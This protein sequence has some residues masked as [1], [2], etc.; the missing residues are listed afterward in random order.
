MRID[1]KDSNVIAKAAEVLEFGGVVMHPTETCYGLAV[2]IF[3]EKAIEKLYKAKGRDFKKP[4]SILVNGLEMAKKYGEFNEAAEKLAEKFWPGALSIVVPRKKSL[5]EFLNPGQDFV[6]IRYSADKFCSELVE[7]YSK[8]ITTTSANLA[9]EPPLYVAE[10][11]S[12]DL[13]L[14]VDDGEIS[15]NKPSTVVKVEGDGIVVLRQG[16]VLVEETG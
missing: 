9:G 2:D 6:S 8:P 11:F 5:P 3:N 1:I 16:G 12:E 13:D 7:A 10:E 14:I 4:V 15:I